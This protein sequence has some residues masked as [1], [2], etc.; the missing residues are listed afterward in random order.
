MLVHDQ[1]SLSLTPRSAAACFRP[2]ANASYSG[3][4]GVDGMVLKMVNG[5]S[6][7]PAPALT[8]AGGGGAR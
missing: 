5:L 8:G 2:T 6:Q 1:S 7:D 4:A 3:F